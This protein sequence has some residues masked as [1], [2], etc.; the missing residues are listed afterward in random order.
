MGDALT[1]TCIFKEE[2]NGH[3]GPYFRFLRAAFTLAS[4]PTNDSWYC[5]TEFGSTPDIRGLKVRLKGSVRD[6]ASS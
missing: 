4:G 1:V 5:P 2:S 3:S 6:A